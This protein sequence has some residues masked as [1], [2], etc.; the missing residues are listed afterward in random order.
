MSKHTLTLVACARDENGN[1]NEWLDYNFRI[2]VDR[3]YL[4]CN[5]D[6]PYPLYKTVLPYTTG[7]NPRLVFRHCPI[8]GAQKVMYRH[9]ID[10]FMGDEEWITFIDVDEFVTIRNAPTLPD[11]IRSM[12]DVDVIQLSWFN[13]GS[14]GHIYDPSGLKLPEYTRRNRYP[15]PEGKVIARVSSIDRQWTTSGISTFF[16]GFGDLSAKRKHQ[17]FAERPLKTV[18][19]WGADYYPIYERN[20]GSYGK[21]YVNEILDTA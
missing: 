9:F 13:F 2:G 10:N 3:I 4:Y 20:F 14:N 21:L 17:P 11:F 7:P 8:P 12:G 6:D 5:D 15:H 19:S 1:I 16:H 18:T